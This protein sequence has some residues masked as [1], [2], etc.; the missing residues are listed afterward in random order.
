MKKCLF[1]SILFVCLAVNASLWSEV[2]I[3]NETY[4]GPIFDD[5]RTLSLQNRSLKVI[6]LPEKGGRVVQVIHRRT[7]RDFVHLDGPEK[8]DLENGI[9]ERL[10]PG[11]S[12]PDLRGKWLDESFPGIPFETEILGDGQVRYTC[13]KGALK[14]ERVLSFAPTLPSFGIRTTVTNIG[15]KPLRTQIFPIYQCNTNNDRSSLY[16]LLAFPESDL[17]DGVARYSELHN[18]FHFQLQHGWFYAC[19]LRSREA[20]VVTYTPN[21]SAIEAAYAYK[22]PQFYHLVLLGK[23]RELRPGDSMSLEVDLWFLTGKE[24]L[25]Q[26]GNAASRIGQKNTETLRKALTEDMARP[27]PVSVAVTLPDVRPDDVYRKPRKKPLFTLARVCWD[28]LYAYREKEDFRQVTSPKALRL[29]ISEINAIRP[30][31]LLLQGSAF[32]GLKDEHEIVEKIL[33]LSKVPAGIIPGVRDSAE[34]FP[35]A[36]RTGFQRLRFGKVHLFLLPRWDWLTADAR[37]DL[38]NAL[39]TLTEGEHAILAGADPPRVRQPDGKNQVVAPELAELLQSHQVTLYLTST[40]FNFLQRDGNAAVVGC[41]DLVDKRAYQVIRIYK[42]RIEI[43]LRKPLGESFTPVIYLPLKPLPGDSLS[44][45][46]PGLPPSEKKA[47]E[48]FFVH[49]ADTQLGDAGPDGGGVG[50][51]LGDLD[52]FK[53]LTAETNALRPAFLIDAGD[54]VERADTEHQWQRHLEGAG[55]SKVPF[56]T[57]LGNHDCTTAGDL[58]TYERWTGEKPLRLHRQSKDAFLFFPYDTYSTS[59]LAGLSPELMTAFLNLLENA[60]DARHLFLIN[61]YP[62]SNMPGQKEEFLK[63]LGTYQ[64]TLW[65]AGHLHRLTYEWVGPTFHVVANSIG[66]TKE[67]PSTAYTGYFIDYVYPDKVILAYK[68]LYEDVTWS[69]EVQKP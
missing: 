58:A 42:D 1:I 59:R 54:L 44:R 55:T 18:E 14:I 29:A 5:L 33:R 10:E 23:S 28:G 22:V 15:E 49:L 65:M 67:G 20:I 26:L 52:R 2:E 9:Y 69:V 34:N 57:A 27:E 11:G 32:N 4:K 13:S 37:Q 61:H 48:Y 7:G 51:G 66:W 40:N 63:I 36:L 19:D 64:P 53:Q 50:R 16:D 39:G 62:F 47:P 68:P 43:D 6:T 38:K 60:R 30:D 21:D 25:T 41:G 17:P 35:E 45:R 24:D 46:F 8:W 31:H 3:R 12:N 56:Y